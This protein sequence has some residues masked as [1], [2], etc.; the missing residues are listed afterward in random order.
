MQHRKL[1]QQFSVRQPQKHTVWGA[2]GMCTEIT[3]KGQEGFLE[4]MMVKEIKYRVTEDLRLS[5]E[6]TMKCTGDVLQNHTFEAYNFINHCH[7]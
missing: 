5:G 4:N 2:Q 3:L 1:I 6:H 7:Q